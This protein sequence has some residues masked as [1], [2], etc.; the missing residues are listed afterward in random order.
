MC[1][2]KT[3]LIFFTHFLLQTL[4]DCLPENRRLDP[5]Q[6]EI[7]KQ[8]LLLGANKKKSKAPNAGHVR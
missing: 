2:I 7:A 4:Y 3:F 5:D 8:E 6:K 1:I